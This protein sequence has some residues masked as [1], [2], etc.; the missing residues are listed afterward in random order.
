MNTKALARH[1]DSLT[2]RER[3]PLILAAAA[4]GDEEERLRLTM[5]APRVSYTLSHHWGLGEALIEVGHWHFMHL[6]A[7]A[8]TYFEGWALFRSPSP[9]GPD[10][11]QDDEGEDAPDGEDELNDDEQ[12]ES[13]RAFALNMAMGY[14]F[15]VNFDGWVLF[16]R[17]QHLEPDVLWT[18][19]PGWGI[20][21]RAEQCSQRA[22]FVAEGAARWYEE[23]TG[24]AEPAPTAE[25]VAANLRAHLKVRVEWWG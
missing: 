19:L 20:I 13:E 1:Y 18:G 9:A 6:L 16:C 25:D 4:R 22:A 21:K 7:L 8:A 11:G 14:L 24:K 17:E 10:D 3:L 2:P 15:R 12:D 5:S 23:G